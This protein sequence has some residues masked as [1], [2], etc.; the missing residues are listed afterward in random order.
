MQSHAHRT[1]G[2]LAVVLSALGFAAMPLF[3]RMA[4][5]DGMNVAT[6][7]FLRFTFAAGLMMCW[8]R[9]RSVAWP[10]RETWPVLFGMGAIGYAGQAACY[11]TALQY[12]TAGMVALL[13]YVY[14][15]LVTLL[16]A[17]FLRESLTRLHFGAVALGT[18]GGMLTIGSSSAH[19]QPLGIVLGL[20]AALIYAGYIIVGKRAMASA[21]PA[22]AGTLVMLSTA[23]VYAIWVSQAPAWPQSW[24]G[25]IAVLGIA[26]V[27]TGIAMVLFLYSMTQLGA[28][29]VSTL[30]T[31]EP[32]MTIVFGVVF[33]HESLSGMQ[34]VGGG[35][36]LLASLLLARAPVTTK[37]MT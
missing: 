23:G 8:L 29:E 37:A 4:Y 25:W 33:L 3:A 15:L 28:A 7:L 12:A 36:I 35:V 22:S 24:L 13:L 31:L 2:L 20:G 14:P 6:L 9:Y 11:F 19:A 17:V 10:P 16:A 34:V 5:A 26:V 27:S 21:P 18:L 30:S 32:L 1:A